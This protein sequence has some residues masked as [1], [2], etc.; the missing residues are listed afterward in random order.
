MT[1]GG[2]AGGGGV[3]SG[4]L[5]VSLVG[6]GL[7]QEG[8]DGASG[9]VG[10]QVAGMRGQSALNPSRMRGFGARFETPSLND[11]RAKQGA[12][13]AKFMTFFQR[14]CT[15][16]VEM[17]QNSFY[18][19]KPNWDKIADFIYNDLCNTAELRKGVIDVQFHPVKMLLFIRFGEEKLRDETVTRLQSAEG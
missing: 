16:V 2:G 3:G 8:L 18:K 9:F 6:P 5:G 15:L 19:Q 12:I 1:G 10:G 7:G 17:Y 4:S 11:M 13:V 14:K